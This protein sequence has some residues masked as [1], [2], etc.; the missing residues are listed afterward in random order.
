[1]QLNADGEFER[2]VLSDLGKS[3]HLDP[4]W[5]EESSKRISTGGMW[6]N[7]AHISPELLNALEE[8]CDNSGVAVFDYK[9]QPSFELGV[10]GF[11]IALG[12][13][14]LPDYPLAFKDG[15]GHVAYDVNSI[16][17]SALSKTGYPEEFCDLLTA[18]ASF[19]ALKRPSL[20]DSLDLF[21]RYLPESEDSTVR[22]KDQPENGQAEQDDSRLCKICMDEE[23][24][25][26]FTPC[27]HLRS[28]LFLRFPSD[29]R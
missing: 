22:E 15:D 28:E 26:A 8:S 24:D 27:G 19:D 14:A 23:L 7:E 16:Q 13:H 6:G 12:D 5:K 20:S 21:S 3:R 9:G 1:V 25:T 2:C 17:D 18:C 29:R 11:E 10:L 4:S